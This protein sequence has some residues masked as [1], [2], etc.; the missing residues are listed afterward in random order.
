LPD[1]QKKQRAFANSEE[2]VSMLE[3]HHAKDANA[4]QAEHD[5][6]ATIWRKIN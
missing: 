5:V 3:D 6:T 1:R 2:A 4:T